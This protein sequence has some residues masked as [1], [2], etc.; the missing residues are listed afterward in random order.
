MSADV[1]WSAPCKDHR[2]YDY[3]GLA[4]VSDFLFTMGYDIRSQIWDEDDCIAWANA[5][6]DDLRAGLLNYTQLFHISPWKLVHGCE[7]TI[8][9][10]KLYVAF[11]IIEVPWYGYDYRCFSLD[12][13]LTCV[14]YSLYFMHRFPICLVFM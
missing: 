13:N 6:I 5:G 3:T 11:L 12:A 7:Y 14:S 4:N 10:L 1:A 8:Y 9:F 2:C